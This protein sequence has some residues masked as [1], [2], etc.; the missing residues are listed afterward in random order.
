[1]PA[2]AL[3]P[4]RSAPTGI[5]QG[6]IGT[7]EKPKERREIFRRI[8]R[9]LGIQHLLIAGPKTG[10]MSK[11]ACCA[12]ACGELL[13]DA[14]A[15]GAELYLTGEMRHHDALRAAEAGMTVVCTL[16]SNSER[17]VLKRLAGKLKGRLPKLAV[18]VSKLDV[19][20]F[21]IA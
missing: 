8:K 3:R 18:Y 1:M 19:D 7:L 21:S 13:K 14:L 4:I 9:E 16:H 15:Q 12:G 2:S 17:A 6:R 5:G 20:P 11:A 10:R